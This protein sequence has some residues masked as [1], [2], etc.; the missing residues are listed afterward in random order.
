VVT[1]TVFTLTQATA[2]TGAPTRTG[3]GSTALAAEGTPPDIIVIMVDDMRADE[4]RYMPWTR[5]LL[6]SK[7]VTFAN[8][9][10]PHP[11]CCPARASVLSGLYTHNHRVFANYDPWGFHAFRDES[12]I[13]T[14]LKG[15][16]Y[17]TAHIGKYLNGYGPD[18]VPGATTGKSLHYVPPGWST[19]RGSIDSGLPRT[20]PLEGGT[21]QYN[22]T[23]LSRGKTLVNYKGQYQ[24]RVY[25]TLTQRVIR[26]RA[27]A[28]SPYFLSVNYA[29]PHAGTPVESDDPA[30]VR[31]SDGKTTVITTPARPGNVRG[32]FDS[33]ITSAPGAT[34]RDP[35]FSDKPA[36][37]ASMPTMNKAERLAVRKLARQ[38]AESLFLV[39]KQVKR[40]FDA[41]AEAGTTGQTLVLFTSDNGYYL[42]EQRIRM[43]KKYH[44]EPSLRV[45]LLIRGPGLPA[46]HRRLDP[47]TSVDL[48]P[49]LAELASVT[50]AHVTDGV[51]LAAVARSGDHGWRRPV[52]TSS[53]PLGNVV[54][55]TNE[56]G[57]PLRAGDTPDVRYALGIR[58]AQ[59]LYVDL[60]NVDRE[61]YDV[62][63]DPQ[64]YHNLAG[65]PGHADV[66]RELASV[67]DRM[68]ACDGPECSEAL[69]GS[70]ARP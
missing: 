5:R 10:A 62:L 52:L 50:P 43:G 13:A 23:T 51:S 17:H 63:A 58:T 26:S 46:G 45:P 9:F 57:S 44:H 36:Y 70:L 3:A 69:P 40:T 32:M 20:H 14:W 29:A 33:V 66:E 39:D 55:S 54:R 42:G 47:I 12:T 59:Y 60:A 64:Q 8:S 21:Y 24:T 28:D 49:T 67:L 68:R 41:L 65:M 53:G 31:R 35:D 61:L 37:L 1:L 19:W 2:L 4:L 15:A 11:L 7:G 34:W 25:G 30:P 22:D 56:D 6:G 48:A 38:R 18:P 27:S 16:G